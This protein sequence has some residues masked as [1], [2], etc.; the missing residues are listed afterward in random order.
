MLLQLRERTEGE[1]EDHALL[2]PRLWEGRP[3][4][5]AP[6]DTR[7]HG[8]TCWNA[9]KFGLVLQSFSLPSSSRPFSPPRCL[10][11]LSLTLIIKARHAP[12]RKVR[13]CRQIKRNFKCPWFHLPRENQLNT[14]SAPGW[15]GS[16]ILNFSGQPCKFA[17]TERGVKGSMSGLFCLF[18]VCLF[19]HFLK[20]LVYISIYF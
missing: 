8:P 9:N 19:L 17:S 11:F 5:L 1:S 13:K 6:Q 2:R 7:R 16:W 18:F 12:Y 3:S 20:F 4:L 14:R 15:R 10:P